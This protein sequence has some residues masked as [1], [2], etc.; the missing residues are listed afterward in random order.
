MPNLDSLE[1]IINSRLTYLV[2]LSTLGV[3]IALNL[4]GTNAL[5]TQGFAVN[6]IEMKTLAVESENKELKIKIEELANLKQ[7][8]SIAQERGFYRAR[9]IV[10]MPTPPATALR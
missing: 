10:F 8:S 2:S 6:D 5:A 1:K 3:L 7:M 4:I 9:D